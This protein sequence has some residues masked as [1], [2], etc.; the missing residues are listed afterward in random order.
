MSF[1]I[2]GTAAT[3]VFWID[4]LTGISTGVGMNLLICAALYVTALIF[5]H[6]YNEKQTGEAGLTVGLSRTLK[7]AKQQCDAI[8]C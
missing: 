7:S 6:L 3:A 2:K 5:W 4:S 8:E 1:S